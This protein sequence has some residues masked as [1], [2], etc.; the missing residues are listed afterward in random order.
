MDTDCRSAKVTKALALALN[1]TGKA[2]CGTGDEP[3]VKAPIIPSIEVESTSN[4]D[5]VQ[6]EGNSPGNTYCE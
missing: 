3:R 5:N 2:G 1:S 6:T 4:W